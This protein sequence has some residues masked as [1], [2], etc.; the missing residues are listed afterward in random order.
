MGVVNLPDEAGFVRIL[1]GEFEGVRG[2]A[3]TFTPVRVFDVR[4]HAGRRATFDIAARD[5]LAVL[6]MAG[7]ATMNG[8]RT[9]QHD[10]VLFGNEGERLVVAAMEETQLLLLSGEPIDEPVVSYGPFVMNSP[11]EIQQA[12]LDFNA[13]RFGHLED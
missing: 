6:V 7:A 8:T 9:V 11:R 2:P 12:F 13:G 10:F 3:S 5:N 4:L 1:A